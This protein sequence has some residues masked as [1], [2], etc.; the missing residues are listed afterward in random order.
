MA[1]IAGTLWALLWWPVGRLFGW[2]TG[3][4]AAVA[5]GFAGLMLG[6][7]LYEWLNL[8]R[9]DSG[10]VRKTLEVAGV[11]IASVAFVALPLWALSLVR[12][13]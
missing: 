13:G 4:G 8:V 9:P 7:M 11:L 1:A 12:A 6:W 2:W 10:R 5:G 3:T